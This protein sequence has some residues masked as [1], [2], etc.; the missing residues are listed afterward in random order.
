MSRRKG[1][2]D[3]QILFQ[4]IQAVSRVGGCEE[5]LYW[6]KASCD[7]DWFILKPFDVIATHKTLES[8]LAEGFKMMKCGEMCVD[9][10]TLLFLMLKNA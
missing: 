10:L 1:R 8:Y 9:L 4:S 2:F 3:A 6:A 5:L 7:V